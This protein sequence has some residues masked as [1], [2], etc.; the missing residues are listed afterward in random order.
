M[1]FARNRRNGFRRQHRL[2][3]TQGLDAE[4]PNAVSRSDREPR[5]VITS[6]KDWSEV[7][8]GYGSRMKDP[9]GVDPD[10]LALADR[11]T[12]GIGTNGRR[13]PPSIRGSRKIFD[14]SMCGWDRAA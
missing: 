10:I 4:E 14:T 7:G 12:K 1:A 5:L 2:T 3:Q 8:A 6:F 13:L 11:I 9:D